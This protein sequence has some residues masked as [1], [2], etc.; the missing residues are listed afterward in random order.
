MK[1]SLRCTAILCI[2][3]ALCLLPLAAGAEGDYPKYARLSNDYFE[4][5]VGKKFEWVYLNISPDI[6]GLATKTSFVLPKTADAVN[7][8][9]AKELE[10]SGINARMDLAKESLIQMILDGTPSK[11]NVYTITFWVYQ[12]S[13][14]D[15]NLKLTI[16]VTDPNKPS[17]SP[18]VDDVVYNAAA[19]HEQALIC[20]VQ[21]WCNVRAGAGTQHE[22]VGR[23]NLGQQI[24]LLCWNA[25]ESWCYVEFDGMEGWIAKQ[26]ILPIK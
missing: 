6:P 4:F 8:A 20:G 2:F 13:G 15:R 9:F 14:T 17:S 21:E 22:I 19:Y 10:G 7:A 12:D 16:K 5:T 23:A 3:L 26:F 24:S 1:R 18:V 25:D 11:E